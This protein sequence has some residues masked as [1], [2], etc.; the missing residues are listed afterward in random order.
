MIWSQN[1]HLILKAQGRALRLQ[2]GKLSRRPL[3]LRTEALRAAKEIARTAAQREILLFLSGG[4]DSETV[5]QVFL[6]AGVRFRPVVIC[7]ENDLNKHD[8][9]PALKYCQSHGLKPLVISFELGKF[10]RSKW[11]KDVAKRYPCF[12]VYQVLMKVMSELNDGER[13]FVLGTAEPEGVH[14]RGRAFL[15][16]F[17]DDV[18]L[19]LFC[20]DR[21]LP[22][23][24]NFFFWSP[25]LYMS[26]L[27]SEPYCFFIQQRGTLYVHTKPLKEDLFSS[28][29]KVK[30]RRKH[31][32]MELA[33]SVYAEELKTLEKSL[34]Q[35]QRLT[36][37]SW[38]AELRRLSSGLIDQSS[39]NSKKR[40]L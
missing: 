29:F 21:R 35:V 30:K 19:S 10:I 15:N 14:R 12:I 9:E 1:Q 36:Y 5:A 39:P 31:N 16:E 4:M 20:S 7:F 26:I 8:V 6:R 3:S 25:E 11:A 27:V 34:A 24:C 23:V 18:Q 33:R 38:S 17:S 2:S 40:K 28:T 32:G 22:A 37:F 13:F